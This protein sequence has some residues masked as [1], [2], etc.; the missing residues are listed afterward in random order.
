M[1][2]WC[3][4]NIA[5]IKWITGVRIIL[6]VLKHKG[7]HTCPHALTDTTKYGLTSNYEKSGRTVTNFFQMGDGAP[8]GRFY[9]VRSRIW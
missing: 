9:E 8:G 1:N 2:N 6:L 5:S 4:N 3:Q 7:Q